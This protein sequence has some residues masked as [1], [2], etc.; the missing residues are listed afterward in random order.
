MRDIS[1]ENRGISYGEMLYIQNLNDEE[2]QELEDDCYE[3]KEEQDTM[4]VNDYIT[5]I[6]FERERR[7]GL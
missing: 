1:D 3:A 5:E 4:L 2:L 7:M 6:E